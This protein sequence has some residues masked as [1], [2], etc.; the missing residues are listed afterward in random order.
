MARALAERMAGCLAGGGTG[1]L[2]GGASPLA[3]Y[4]LLAE[5]D[6]VP[7]E[8]II[9]MPTDERV[10]PS[11]HHE[12]NDTNLRAIFGGRPCTIRGLPFGKDDRFERFFRSRLPASVTLLGLGEDGHTASLFPGDPLVG[13]AGW[14]V[15]VHNAP[16]PP[17][18]RVSLTLQALGSTACLL[19]CVTGSAKKGPLERLLKGEDIP[20]SR[21]RPE[22]PPEIYCDRAALTG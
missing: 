3:S 12:R 4:R 15:R 20:A 13:S 19:F 5:K 8:K 21:L 11:G 18:E 2:A 10:L 1:L 22:G 16:K 7:W 6:D 17:S 9:L 14:L